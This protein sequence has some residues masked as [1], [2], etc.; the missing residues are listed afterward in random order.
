MEPRCIIS[1]PSSARTS[2]SSRPLR[3]T[4]LIGI[5][6]PGQAAEGTP[7]HIKLISGSSPH[8]RHSLVLVAP[9]G[10]LFPD[11]GLAPGHLRRELGALT[12][13]PPGKFLSI[14]FYDPYLQGRTEQSLGLQMVYA[15]QDLL[16]SERSPCTI[17]STDI[18]TTSSMTLL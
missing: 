18:T 9:C 8:P 12:T 10:I 17:I 2:R 7:L 5:K 13:G 11:Q 15:P 3:V 6:A 16:L 1:S 4:L 14:I